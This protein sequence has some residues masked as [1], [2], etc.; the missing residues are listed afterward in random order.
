MCHCMRV[1]RIVKESIRNIRDAIDD[2]FINQLS[3][4]MRLYIY[5][6]VAVCAIFQLDRIGSNEKI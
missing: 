1:W 5:I 4:E 2:S 3:V 6:V